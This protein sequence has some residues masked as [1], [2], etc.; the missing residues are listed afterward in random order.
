[1]AEEL[2]IGR[3]RT[4]FGLA[5]E[6]KVDLYGG[7]AAHLESLDSVIVA[8]GGRRT[9]RR[10]AAVRPS[11]ASVLV[12]FEGVDTPDDAKELRNSEL[13]VDRSLAAP[14]GGGEY[15]YA[16]LVGLS[17]RA[18]GRTFGT[19]LDILEGSG[20]VFLETKVS[21][22]SKRIVP[23]TPAFIERVDLTEGSVTVTNPEILA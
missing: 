8:Q 21:D 7:D 5:G 3:V 9:T 22:G 17:V 10:I 16:D 23:F 11:G 1:M 13:I 2:V 18:D 20:A 19:V 6:V 14:L 12:R 15:Y 4:A